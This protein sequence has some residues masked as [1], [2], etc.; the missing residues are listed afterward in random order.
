[1]F[2]RSIAPDNCRIWQLQ[3]GGNLSA[4]HGIRR[5]LGTRMCVSSFWDDD[6]NAQ[7]SHLRHSS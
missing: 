5:H 1:M 6:S 4:L 3:G 7:Y 2:E